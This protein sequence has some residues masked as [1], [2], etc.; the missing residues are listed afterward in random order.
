M[1]ARLAPVLHIDRWIW[2]VGVTPATFPDVIDM[3][4]ST[5]LSVLEIPCIADEG[6]FLELHR[7]AKEFKEAVEHDADLYD[8]QEAFMELEGFVFEQCMFAEWLFP[9]YIEPGNPYG[10]EMSK[11]PGNLPCTSPGAYG[12]SPGN[13]CPYSYGDYDDAPDGGIVDSFEDPCCCKL[14]ADLEYIGTRF[15]I[16]TL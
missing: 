11:V 10:F 5:P 1:G 3:L 15:G 12:N 9:S 4:H 2:E 8:K 13:W 14:I 7:L 16:T 6:V